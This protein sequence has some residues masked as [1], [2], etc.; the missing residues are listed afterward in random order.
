MHRPSIDPDSPVPL[1]YQIAELI[2]SSI[3]S[4]ELSPGDALHPLR[5]AAEKWGVHLHT[6]RHAYAALAR[7]GLVE[8]RRGATGTRVASQEAT[9]RELTSVR[10][11]RGRTADLSLFLQRFFRDGETLFGLGQGELAAAVRAEVERT[12]A[13]RS[14]A[15]YVTE[16]SAHQCSAHA[17]EIADRYDVD[18][19]PWPLAA[20]APPPG[21][22]IATYFHYNDIRRHWPRRLQ[23]VRFMTIRPAAGI[24][25][26]IGRRSG[27]IRVC[28]LDI[29]TAEAVMGDVHALLG[30]TR[31]KLV[32]A[33]T[34]LPANLL[35][36]GGTTPVLYPPRVWARLDAN[37]RQDPRAI[38]LVY[39]LDAKE[40]EQ[41]ASESGWRE[42]SLHAAS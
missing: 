42:H 1:Y 7:E 30:R 17:R 34:N 32:P 6:V 9:P 8:I 29:E 2:R 13:S 41:F 37:S 20:G 18:A 25:K 16:C 38:E 19:R 23:S 15:V 33:V 28:E 11:R 31:L 12:S 14:P 27:T 3:L 26:R 39:T 5:V 36:G 40:L 10:S 4:G 22:V 35:R 24:R 21:P